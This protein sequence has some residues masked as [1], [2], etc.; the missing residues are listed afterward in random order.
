[1]AL[2]AGAGVFGGSIANAAELVVDLT[3]SVPQT[4]TINTAIFT[5]NMLQPTGTGVIRPFV[6]LD[7]ASQPIE[8]GFNTDFRP[9]DATNDAKQDAQYTHSFK[10]ADLENVNGYYEFLLDAN[11]TG[12]NGSLLN[13]N[14]L[15]IY[16]SNSPDL[17]GYTGSGFASGSSTLVYNMDGPGIADNGVLLDVQGN[18]HGSGSGDLFVDVPVFSGGTYVYLYSSFGVPNPN[19]DG[20][21]EWA[22]IAKEGTPSVPLPASLWGGLALLGFLGAAK[23]RS[24]RQSA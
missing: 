13:L 6:R 11:Q 1:L 24:R 7:N 3:G 19:N 18:N 9:I 12:G 15:Q 14:V 4:T 21:E 20:F 8:K 23:I 22:A 2:A 17:H 5:T 16:V 10:V